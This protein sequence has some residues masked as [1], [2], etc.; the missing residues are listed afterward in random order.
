MVIAQSKD[1]LKKLRPYINDSKCL[2]MPELKVEH[3]KMLFA[4]SSNFE[5]RV[6][7]DEQML[8]R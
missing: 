1:L 5:P 7:D 2:E 8:Q 3:A 4:K 6:E